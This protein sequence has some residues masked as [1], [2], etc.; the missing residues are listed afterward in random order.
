M[1]WSTIT[2][3]KLD[4]GLLNWRKMFVSI[5]ED[6]GLSV[7]QSSPRVKLLKLPRP[8]LAIDEIERRE[9]ENAR[10]NSLD[11]RDIS[12]LCLCSSGLAIRAA[13]FSSTEI[14]DFD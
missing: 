6:M 7:H 8:C 9:W 14:C 10:R 3:H 11:M 4:C 12:A 5:Y 1:F 2:P 13:L